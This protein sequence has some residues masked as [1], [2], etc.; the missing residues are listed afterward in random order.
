MATLPVRVAGAGLKAQRRQ[1]VAACS[2]TPASI[3]TLAAGAGRARRPCVSS[4]AHPPGPAVVSDAPQLA[5]TLGTPPSSKARFPCYTP[6]TV[7]IPRLP[8]QKPTC[9]ASPYQFCCFTPF[10][11]VLKSVLG[12]L[13][14]IGL[15]LRSQPALPR[16]PKEMR[17]RLEGVLRL[18][19]LPGFAPDELSLLCAILRR[20]REQEESLEA[21]Q[22]WNW[23]KKQ[24]LPPAPELAS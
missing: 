13:D 24:K 1:G 5:P 17:E 9:R 23:S 3:S 20:Q 11:Q 8:V 2:P 19:G 10:P 4:R 18:S 6:S 16:N 12:H 22:Q 7:V 21:G 14:T 15:L